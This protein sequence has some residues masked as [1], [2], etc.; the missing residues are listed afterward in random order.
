[1]KKALRWLISNLGL[2]LLSLILAVLVWAAAVEQGNPTIERRFPS[3]IP[4]TVTGV[5]EGMIAYGETELQVHVTLRAP[6]SV[7]NN[8]QQKDLRAVVDLSGLDAGAHQVPIDVQVDQGPVMERGVEPRTAAITLEPRGENRVPVHIRIEGN[9]A[10][11][12]TA[13]PAVVS[14][15]T[16]TVSGPTSLVAQVANATATV[17][18]EGKRADV[19]GE[20]ELR[21]RDAEGEAMPHI[22]VSPATV[23]I[24]VPIE[25]LSGFRDLAITAV[26][27]GQVAPGYRISSVTVDPPVVTAYGKPEVIAEIPGYLQTA[28]MDVEGETSDKEVRLPLQPPEG[29]SLL[30]EEPVVTVRVD[31]VPVEG[32]LTLQREVTVQGLSPNLTAIVAPQSVEVILTGPLSELEQLEQDDVRVIADVFGLSPG[33]HSVEPKAVVTPEDIVAKSIL[34]ATVQVE[35]TTQVTPTPSR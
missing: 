2:I 22:T 24:R 32:S 33:S 19:E 35:I 5:P 28:P 20:F 7:W 34:P 8:L 12:Y 10:L 30:M 9:T 31:I 18:V 6:T 17:S 4:V 1:M 26:L 15:V 14:P 16:A 21:P 11:G 23:S 27:E 3:A 29:V 13:R 25:Q